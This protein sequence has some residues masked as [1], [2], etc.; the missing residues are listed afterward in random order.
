MDQD[1]F[2]KGGVDVKVPLF[3]EIFKICQE[4][5]KL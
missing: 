2:K 5:G 3:L 4:M 1:F